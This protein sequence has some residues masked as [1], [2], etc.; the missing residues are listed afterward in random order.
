VPLKMSNKMEVYHYIIA[1]VGGFFAGVVN[2][3]AGN[4]SA[5]TLTILTE[6]L[7]LPPN[8]ANGTNRIGV[9]AQTTASSYGFYQGGKLDL[10]QNWIFYIPTII[11]AIIGVFIAINVSNEQFK[12]FFSYMMVFMLFVILV[13]PK[14]W[15][16]ESD[17]SKRPSNWITVPL[18]FLLGIYGGFIQMGMGIFFLAITVLIARFS[19]IEA[20]GMKAFIIAAYTALVLA[21][22]QHQGLVNWQVGSII[23]IGQTVGGYVTARL[24]SSYPQANVV[25]HRILVAV[26]ILAI[27]RLFDFLGI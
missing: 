24:A 16:A 11:G 15:L 9:V 20:N 10:R 26:V 23:A 18:F 6:V 2:T 1:I 19:L 22:F 21:V 4:G 3:L 7:G 14:R 25:A 13:R 8:L 5:I 27:L 12:T 17:H